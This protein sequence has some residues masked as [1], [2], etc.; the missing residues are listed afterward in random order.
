MKPVRFFLSVVGALLLP[1]AG[2]S[3]THAQGAYPEPVD[4]YVND[5]AGLLTVEHA[6]A[7]RGLLSN[8]KRDT[9]VEAVVVTIGSINDYATGD[10]TIESFAT[11][12]FNTWGV[13]DKAKNNGVLILVAVNDRKVRIEV[14]AG[15]ESTLN[16]AMQ[17]VIDEYMLPAF[18]RAD[19]SQG[20]YDGVRAVVSELTGQRPGE[21]VATARPLPTRAAAPSSPRAGSGATGVPPVAVIGGL[22]LGAG[23]ATLGLRRYARY[24]RRRCPNC[25]TLMIRLDEV[26]DDVH[27][28]SGQKLEEALAS[29]DYDVWKCPI[30]SFHALQGYNKLFSG[31]RRCSKCSYRTLEVKFQTISEPTYTSTGKKLITQLCRHCHNRIEETVILPMLTQASSD[32]F[33]DSGGSSIDSGGS[34]GGFGGGSSSGGG[35]SGSW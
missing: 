5:F 7:I 17:K 29:V 31:M 12:L 9:G 1:A 22:S 21:L 18:R 33:G 24:H 23:A 27:L 10:A 28:N 8:L 25:G 13:G 11:N 35:A 34:S 2:G 3:A 16:A 14:G 32:N 30:C 4:L 26:S 15:Y 6:S 19:Y 20:I